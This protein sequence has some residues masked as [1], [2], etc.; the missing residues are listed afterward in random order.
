MKILNN[1]N[2][3][4][5]GQVS[6]QNYICITTNQGWNKLGHNVM[7]A[8]VALEAVKRFPTLAAVYGK[9]CKDEAPVSVKLI[10]FDEAKLVMFP[11]KKL[12]ED[13]PYLSWKERSCLDLIRK[14]SVE[15]K[16]LMD[17]RN[18][19]NVFLPAPGCG[20][21]G[22]SLEQVI[23]VLESVFGADERLNVIVRR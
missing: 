13:V 2:F 14:S 1:P 9:L 3:Y 10:E 11:T 19:E 20:N 17:E 12:N 18:P 4:L 6:P 5:W 7:G 16:T 21:G 8:G 15:L 22:L 23:P